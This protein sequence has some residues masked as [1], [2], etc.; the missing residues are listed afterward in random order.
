MN[1]I[2]L[3]APLIGSFCE[4]THY[5]K[6]SAGSYGETEAGRQAATG[7]TSLSGLLGGLTGSRTF[8][9]ALWSKVEA[10]TSVGPCRVLR[11]RRQVAVA[12]VV[13][14]ALVVGSTGS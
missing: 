4:P 6:S 10:M 12:V 11:G 13:P 5:D 8:S 2:T 3:S 1:D 7:S 14:T 9:S